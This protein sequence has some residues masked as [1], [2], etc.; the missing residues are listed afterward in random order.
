MLGSQ[1]V[2]HILRN[3]GPGSGEARRGQIEVSAADFGKLRSI[4]K[5]PGMIRRASQSGKH[6]EPRIEV[7][8]TINGVQCTYVA[9]VQR[10]KRRLDAVTM[11]KR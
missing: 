7:S 10:R 4:L 2:S 6:G 1:A 5:E 3:H 11:W 9:E 8:K